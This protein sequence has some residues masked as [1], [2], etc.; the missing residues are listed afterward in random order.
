MNTSLLQSINESVVGEDREN[1][2]VGCYFDHKSKELV[3]VEKQRLES[4]RKDIRNVDEWPWLMYKKTLVGVTLK[5]VVDNLSGYST[6]IPC[7]GGSPTRDIE[8]YFMKFL[9]A[10]SNIRMKPTPEE[11]QE[12]HP[13][14]NNWNAKMT[15]Q[16]LKNV[17]LTREFEIDL[18]H[19]AVDPVTFQPPTVHNTHKYK[20]YFISQRQAMTTVTSTGKD[21]T[22]C[23]RFN[24][25]QIFIF[26]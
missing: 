7:V 10:G 19:I 8:S 2:L 23:D 6:K 17:P 20:T 1:F 25:E 15:Y 16:K 14:W 24:N 5:H 9:E 26:T 12:L 13:D 21:Y 11:C 4:A 22:F 3:K 18:E